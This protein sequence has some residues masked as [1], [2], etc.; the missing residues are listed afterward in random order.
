MRGRT[1]NQ[2]PR[3]TPTT[4]RVRQPYAG[5]VGRTLGECYARL[6]GQL[7]ARGFD[8]FVALVAMFEYE[9]TLR[10]PRTADPSH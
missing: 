4:R 8:D 6:T 1:P 7:P 3:A 9:G 2:K 5:D 10:L